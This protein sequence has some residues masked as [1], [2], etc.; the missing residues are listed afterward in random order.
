MWEKGAAGG[1]LS[2]NSVFSQ[3]AMHWDTSLCWELGGFNFKKEK[4]KIPKIFSRVEGLAWLG[5]KGGNSCG[6]LYPLGNALLGFLAALSPSELVNL[7]LV[8]V[9]FFY[10]IFIYFFN[11]WHDLPSTPQSCPACPSRVKT[12]NLHRSRG[13][14]GVN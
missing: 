4:K 13:N 2:H 14:S 1:C 11:P 10:F 7:S 3:F 5:E 6:S 12:G 9:F 8:G